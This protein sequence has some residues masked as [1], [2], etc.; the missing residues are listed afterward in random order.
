M[1]FVVLLAPIHEGWL[2]YPRN[3]GYILFNASFSHVLFWYIWPR[4]IISLIEGHVKY[5][6]VW[7]FDGLV[8][9]TLFQLPVSKLPTISYEEYVAKKHELNN[10]L[11]SGMPSQFST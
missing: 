6:P 5:E 4:E 1:S 11:Y 7:S 3:V 2:C 10:P 9:P 8:M